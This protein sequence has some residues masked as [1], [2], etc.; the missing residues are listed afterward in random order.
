MTAQPSEPVTDRP[1]H[2]GATPHP[3]LRDESDPIVA[4]VR[5]RLDEFYSTTTTYESFEAP[6]EKPDF[7]GPIRE[8]IARHVA[9]GGRARVLEFGAGRTTFPA[10]LGE[11]RSRVDF[12]AQDVATQNEAYLRERADR[13]HIGDLA[14][15]DGPYDVIFSTFVWE[16]VTT[17]RATLGELFRLLAP[18][19]R[20]YIACPRYDFPGYI[21]PSARHYPRA[22]RL[23][24]ACA[25]ALRRIRVILG[26]RAAFLIH[27]DP[28]VFHRPWY[29]DADAIHWA[30]AYDLRRALPPGARLDT[31]G[32][33]R[34]TLK[35]RLSARFLLLFVR[36]TKPS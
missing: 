29:R 10:F 6:S 14:A 15:L 4:D 11:L 25:L 1:R 31:L 30:S 22:V 28:S 13:V 9:A 24:L 23:R 16:H 34:A 2:R 26:G 7:W 36:I 32:V 33:P 35:G 8:D 21:S 17:P 19:G 12:H 20:L 5:R 3:V 18:G 27:A